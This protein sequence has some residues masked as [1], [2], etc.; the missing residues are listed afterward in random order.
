[1]NGLAVSSLE[2]VPGVRRV[3]REESGELNVLKFILEE[4]A[5]LGGVINK[6]NE[7]S[8]KIERLDKH[9]PTLEDVFVRL[10]GHSMD[11]IEKEDTHGDDA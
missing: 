10:V 2:K 1:M 3:G 6:L 11:E 5:A 4:E 7:F 8:V 9:E